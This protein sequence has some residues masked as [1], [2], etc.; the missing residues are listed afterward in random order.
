MGQLYVA[1]ALKAEGGRSNHHRLSFMQLAVSPRSGW[2]RGQ[3]QMKL[4]AFWPLVSGRI[5][6]HASAPQ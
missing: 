2:Q 6:L 1:D 5:E 3:A 4:Q